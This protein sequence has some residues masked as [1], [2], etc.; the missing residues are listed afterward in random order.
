MMTRRA[1]PAS[2][3]TSTASDRPGQFGGEY[4]LDILIAESL[5]HL[6]RQISG[7]TGETGG[8]GLVGQPGGQAGNEASGADPLGKNI[9]VEEVLLYE[10]AERGGE[11]ILALDD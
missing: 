1:R 2:G 7:V 10:L 5:G 8:V 4:A 9:G 3:A 11:L 6:D